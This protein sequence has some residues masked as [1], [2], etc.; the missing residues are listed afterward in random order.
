M[1]QNINPIFDNN[2]TAI[3][4]SSSVE[5]LPYLSVCL[6]SLFEHT[7]NNNKYDIIIF[8]PAD[9]QYLKQLI[10]DTYT[11]ENISVRFYN[12]RE[13]LSDTKLN[14]TYDY[15]NEACYYRITAPIVL[16]NYK[17][18][19]FTDIDIIFNKDIDLLS[20][21]DIGEYPVAACSEPIW[22]WFIDN[23]IE[24]NGKINMKKYSQDVLKLKDIRTYFNTGV[25]VINV[26]E[27]KK[28][29]YFEKIKEL[30][31][32]NFF[33][34]Q[35]QCAINCLLNDKI[36]RLDSSW[37]T[38]IDENI[39]DTFHSEKTKIIHFLGAKKPWLHPNAKYAYIWWKYARRSP[40]YETLLSTFINFKINE[41]IQLEKDYIKNTFDYKKCKFLAKCTLGGAQK[42]Y[43]E[44]AERL[45]NKIEEFEKLHK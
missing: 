45:K 23:D 28:N 30:I 12:P 26:E 19:I 43:N 17:K 15:F 34:Y 6:Q 2:C 33:I 42:H 40:F 35:E 29:N 5:Y 37:N 11:K 9:D 10:I 20:K 21:I 14:I 27:F 22:E 38:E 32:N 41:N 24:F 31:N 18:I 25:M 7:S 39:P 1:Q 4:M 8:S 13:H 44:K 3:A 16:N 36:F